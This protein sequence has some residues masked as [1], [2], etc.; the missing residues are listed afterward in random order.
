MAPLDLL[1]ANDRPG[2]YPASYYAAGVADV[3]PRAALAGD[4]RVDVAIVGG[5][6]TGLSA[7]FHL[8]QRGYK[9]ALL[10]AHLAGWGASGRNGGQVGSGQRQDQ[11]FLEQRY[12]LEMAARLW[13]LAEEAKQLVHDLIAEHAIG[14]HVADGIIHADHRPRYVAESRA[15]AEKLADRYGY[16]QISF[17][18]REALRARVRSEAYHGGYLDSGAF[19][20]DPLAYARGLARA[21]EAAG[22]VVY[23]NSQAL[24]I[25]KGKLV[26]IETEKGKLTADHLLLACNGY[27]GDLEPAIARRVLPINNFVAVTEKLTDQFRKQLLPDIAAVADSKFVI[28]YFRMTH[29]NR[30]LF[31][32]GENYGYRFPAD[33]KRFVQRPMLEIFPQ[34]SNTR[35]DYAWGG[36]L[37]ITRY[38]LPLFDRLAP[39]VLTCGGYSGHGISIA[40]LGGKL[41]AEAIA[42]QSERFDIMARLDTPPFPGGA[43]LRYP[44]LV[45]AMLWFSLRDR[46]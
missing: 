31:G 46:L 30:L 17:L 13:E 2:E 4:R 15:Y 36:T 3:T 39:N 41:A 43:R 29:D 7:A 42:G 27:L 14:C 25:A 26:E 24:R 10:E 22:A 5:G 45:L 11:D 38:R 23:E 8:A 37:A 35:I 20:L 1:H 34:L 12:G 19:H 18:D 21:A 44:I 9:V 16:D 28:N 33:I 40:T 6:F 32:G